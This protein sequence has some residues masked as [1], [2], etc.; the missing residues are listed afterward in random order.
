MPRKPPRI[1]VP[2]GMTRTNPVQPP[3]GPFKPMPWKPPSGSGSSPLNPFP[4]GRK[5]I[6]P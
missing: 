2:P 3:V 4:K 1:N 5:R 6:I